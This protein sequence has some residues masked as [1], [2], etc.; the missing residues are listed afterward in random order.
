MRDVV[1]A[2]ISF[3]ILL[4]WLFGVV[5]AKGFWSTFFAAII[6]FYAWYLVVEHFAKY[7]GVI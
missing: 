5:I 3:F 1:G 2:I 4:T 7:F 6:P